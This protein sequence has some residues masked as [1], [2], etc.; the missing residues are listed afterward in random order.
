M[1]NIFKCCKT[2]LAEDC[3]L[4]PVESFRQ[5]SPDREESSPT[6]RPLRRA[7]GS[8]VRRV[9]QRQGARGGAPRGPQGA[10]EGPGLP[11]PGW[12]GSLQAL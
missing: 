12:A 4:Q 11:G 1:E 9:Q 2:T 3:G 7:G 6:T 5:S 10:G 8:H